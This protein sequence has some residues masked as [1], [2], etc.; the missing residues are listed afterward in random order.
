MSKYAYALMFDTD[1][2]L[3]YNDI[4]KKITSLP[5][6]YSWFHYLRCSYV[7]ISEVDTNAITQE[8]IKIIPNKR[9]LIFRID[10]KSRNGW[11]P[12]EAWDWI[13]KMIGIVNS[14]G[15]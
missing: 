12:K 3:D 13:E 14:Q 4:H 10:L 2:N 5:D 8:M 1:D 6:L 7:L 15:Y 9:F 11:L